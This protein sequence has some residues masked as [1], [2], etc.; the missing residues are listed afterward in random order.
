MACDFL[1][2]HQPS[3]TYGR[4]M[5]EWVEA[6]ANAEDSRTE[7][8]RLFANRELASA[9]RREVALT[10][11]ENPSHFAR[12]LRSIALRPVLV[13]DTETTGLAALDVVIQLGYCLLADGMVIEE[14]EKVWRG[15]V[16]SNPFALKVHKIPN[17]VVLNSPHDPREE[18]TKFADLAKRVKEAGGVLVAHNAAFDVR[19]LSHMAKKFGVEGFDLGAVFCTAKHL[20]QVPCA[21]RGPTCKNA[22]V[23]Q[24]LGGPHMEFHQAL[25]DAKATAY[26]YEHGRQNAWW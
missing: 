9:T 7:L 5:W 2:P 22:D 18:L 1:F 15:D 20:K 23:Y 17:R 24:F 26:V 13:F 10:L 16:P 12:E 6:C 14:Y 21:D 19:M 4:P 3:R 8:M 11:L 25:N